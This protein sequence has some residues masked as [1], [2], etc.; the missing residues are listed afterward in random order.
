MK[1]DTIKAQLEG[2]DALM[3]D[4]FRNIKKYNDEDHVDFLKGL[5]KMK[6]DRLKSLQTENSKTA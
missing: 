3:N 2:I 5:V 6:A 4:T 1:A